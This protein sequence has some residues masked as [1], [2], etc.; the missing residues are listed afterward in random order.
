[1]QDLTGAP[2]SL[3]VGCEL[4]FSHVTIAEYVSDVLTESN[5]ALLER[6]PRPFLSV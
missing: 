1:L 6:P 4:S 5:P 2:A 3:I